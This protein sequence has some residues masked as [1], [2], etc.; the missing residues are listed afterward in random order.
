MKDRVLVSGNSWFKFR[1]TMPIG[2][3]HEI[4][5]QRFSFVYFVL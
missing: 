5:E 2:I 4:H 1:A 3:N